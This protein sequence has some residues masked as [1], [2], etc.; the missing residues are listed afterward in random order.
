M[1][2]MTKARRRL[3]YIIVILMIM[4]F[5]LIQSNTKQPI[6]N[7]PDKILLYKNTSTIEL[8]VLD[9]KNIVSQINKNLSNSNN[10]DFITS[11]FELSDLGNQ[12]PNV[13]TLLLT[14]NSIQKVKLNGTN[15]NV[16]YNKIIITNKEESSIIYFIN[17]NGFS[18]S[19]LVLK[20]I[21]IA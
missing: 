5:Y 16:K 14:Y 13:S 8:P 4:T 21:Q 15:N 19:G 6:I 1:K 3:L 18:T 9:F 10:N 17:K 2:S 11:I 12:E 20:K 7:T